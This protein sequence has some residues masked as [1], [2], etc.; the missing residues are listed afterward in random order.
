[1]RRELEA[2]FVKQYPE[3]APPSSVENMVKFFEKDSESCIRRDGQFEILGQLNKDESVALEFS[4]QAIAR[5]N[6]AV[7]SQNGVQYISCQHRGP[8]GVYQ[9]TR[10]MM[11]R[12]CGRITNTT[13]W[14]LQANFPSPARCAWSF[15]DARKICRYTSAQDMALTKSESSV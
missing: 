9:F 4:K 1:M 7:T 10:V 6:P 15:T 5:R 3:I 2:L 13:A 14:R 11:K 8:D 12:R